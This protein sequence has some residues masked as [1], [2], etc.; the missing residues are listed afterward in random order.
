M[1]TPPGRSAPLLQ[2]I[3]DPPQE[4]ED[5]LEGEADLFGDPRGKDFKMKFRR[6]NCEEDLDTEQ[7]LALGGMV[8]G[9]GD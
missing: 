7:I 4:L 5:D 3:L 2:G 6:Q 9:V 1:L 8:S